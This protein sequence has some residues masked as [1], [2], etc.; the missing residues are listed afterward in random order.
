MGRRLGKAKE[1]PEKG[2]RKAK[3]KLD[4]YTAKPSSVSGNSE[5]TQLRHGLTQFP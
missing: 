4:N 3:G 2:Q 1:R 5:S